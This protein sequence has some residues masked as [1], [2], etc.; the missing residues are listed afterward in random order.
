MRSR[1]DEKER[2][3]RALGRA[4]TIP[5]CCFFFR[6]R[7][8]IRIPRFTRA[9]GME[10]ALSAKISLSGVCPINSR[11]LKRETVAGITQSGKLVRFSVS[12]L[13]PA[14]LLRAS[15]SSGGARGVLARHN[16]GRCRI[17]ASLTQLHVR[18]SVT[19]RLD[20]ILSEESGPLAGARRN[21]SRISPVIARF[22][23]WRQLRAAAEIASRYLLSSVSSLLFR[24][25]V[26]R[27]LMRITG[28]V[29]ATPRRCQPGAY[30][31]RARAR[32]LARIAIT[33]QYFHQPR[34][35]GD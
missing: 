25:R 24:E 8:R 28:G 27:G 11:R 16:D 7:T 23:G 4:A 3:N 33:R 34:S 1:D 12:H 35:Y 22:T 5:R 9:S 20:L 18:A 30:H 31:L 21:A 2:A 13:N 29:R 32:S 19:T 15:S 14:H 17:R 26:H 10:I 6:I